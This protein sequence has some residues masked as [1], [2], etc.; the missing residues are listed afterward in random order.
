ML[1][2]IL[3]LVFGSGLTFISMQ[4]TQEVSLTFYRYT[5]SNLPVYFVILGSIL[6]GVIL[7]YFISFLNSISTHMLIRKQYKKIGKEKQTVAELTKRIHQLELENVKL[8]SKS[9]PSSFDQ[10]SL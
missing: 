1:S 5:F 2:L 10:K 8:K 3:L 9:E 7:A 4:N 6:V